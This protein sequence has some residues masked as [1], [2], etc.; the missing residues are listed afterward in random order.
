MLAAAFVISAP[1]A[2]CSRTWTR[3]RGP[4]RRA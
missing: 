1:A 2:R 3:A 4:A